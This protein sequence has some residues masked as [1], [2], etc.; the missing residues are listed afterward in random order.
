MIQRIKYTSIEENNITNESWFSDEINKDEDDGIPSTCGTDSCNDSNKEC[1]EEVVE[2]EIE[3]DI[4]QPTLW[5]FGKQDIVVSV[6]TSDR[7]W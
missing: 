4:A 2:R 7:G 6:V 3:N 5:L 1:N